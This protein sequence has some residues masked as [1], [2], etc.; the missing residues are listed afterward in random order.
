MSG[1]ITPELRESYDLCERVSKGRLGPLWA[2]TELLP[3]EVRPH[4]CAVGGFAVWTDGVADEGEPADRERVLAQWCTDSLAEARAGRSEHP[5]RRALVHTVREWDL[6]VQIV[7]EFLEAT[8]AD[9]AAP[10]AFATFADQRRFLRGV[11]GTIAE[12]VTPLLRPDHREATRL[13]SLLGELCQLADIAQDFPVDLAAGR[14][15]LPREDLERLGLDLGDIQRGEPRDALDELIGIQAARARNL[16]EQVTPVAG[17][18]DVSCQP[19]V[20]AVVLG[21]EFH[22]REVE[23]LGARVLAEGVD[24]EALREAALRPRREPPGGLEVPAHVAVIMDGNRRW[25][26][27]RGLPAP[28]GHSAGMRSALRLIVSALRLGIAHLS[29]FGFS[30]ENW[31][32][33]PEELARLFDTASEGITRATE[34]L[35]ERGVRVRWCGHRDRLDESVASALAIVENLTSNNTVLTL[36]VFADYGGHDELVSAA[37]A[38]AA[39]AVAGTIR[40]EDIGPADIARNCCAPDLPQVDLLIRTSGEQRI[41]NFLPWHLAYAELVFEPAPWPDFG[42]RHLLAALADYAGRQR[43]FGSDSPGVPEP[44]GSG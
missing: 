9:C 30:T 38:L 21:A 22:W 6:D 25:A 2:A 10:P 44:A 35:H 37:R 16:L 28:Q 3:A 20:H 32:R 7:E 33:S 24:S 5:L 8:R 15:Y 34:W 19:F 31:S 41:S 23:R 14:C 39:E 29:V 11:A 18:V 43:R 42:H 26:A 17:M 12:L 1:I 27:Q 36:N 4:F 40:P 13:M